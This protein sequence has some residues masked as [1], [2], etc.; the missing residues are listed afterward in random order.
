MVEIDSYKD[1]LFCKVIEQRKLHKT[2]EALHYW[3]KIFA[4]SISGFFVELNPDIKNKTV[5]VNVFSEEKQFPDQSDVIENS[6]QW[7]SPH[8]VAH[9]SWRSPTAEFLSQ[10]GK[11]GRYLTYRIKDG[12]VNNIPT[13]TFHG[14]KPPIASGLLSSS[15]AEVPHAAEMDHHLSGK[16]C[17]IDR[18]AYCAGHNTPLTRIRYSS[19]Q[20]PSGQN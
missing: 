18:C 3:L 14:R 2:D 9:H 15:D 5:P 13:I 16:F 11:K 4:N 8:G 19:R 1:D 6:G 10:N 12:Q 17:L 7:F 20:P